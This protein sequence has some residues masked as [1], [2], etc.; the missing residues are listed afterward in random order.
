MSSN[1][2][3]SARLIESLRAVGQ[4]EQAA[5][6][7]RR[8]ARGLD[9]R[10]AVTVAAQL[11]NADAVAT[12]IA[13]TLGDPAAGATHAEWLGEFLAAQPETVVD[14]ALERARARGLPS[15]AE[16][17][18]AAVERVAVIALQ[19]TPCARLRAK[20]LVD[21]FLGK[22]FPDRRRALAEDLLARC[23]AQL[24]A[25]AIE[26]ITLEALVMLPGDQLSRLRAAAG[27]RQPALDRHLEG[28]ALQVLDALA[29]EAS[30]NVSRA[31]DSLGN[32]LYG[33]SSHFVLEFLQNADD[34]GARAWAIRFEPDRVVIQHD[35][36]AF[37]TRDVVGVTGI[38]QSTKRAGQI[39]TFGIGFKSVYQVTR[40]PRI[41]SGLF[42]FEIRDYV[43]PHPF[44]RRPDAPPG[45]TVFEL[46]LDEDRREL[47]G[48][49]LKQ[50]LSLDP[51]VLV[52]L[53][54]VREISFESRLGA[55][56]QRLVLKVSHDEDAGVHTVRRE[57]DGHAW[58][59]AIA[60]ADDPRAMVA[61]ELDKAGLPRR[62]E[63]DAPTVF[64]FLPTQEWSG[65]GFRL[66]GALELKMD[67]EHV[68]W[69]SARNERLLERVPGL[70]AEAV[71]KLVRRGGAQA[72]AAALAVL[73]A[74]ADNLQANF[75]RRLLPALPGALR[76]VP[77]I[78][79][80]DGQVRAPRAVIAYAR[81]LTPLL[82]HDPIDAYALG[83]P[84]PGSRLYPV[85]AALDERARQLASELGARALQ[86]SD[87]PELLERCLGR[88]PSG[89]RPT[90][91]WIPG[92][93]RRLD[94]G[95]LTA[96]HELL[97]VELLR[98]ERAPAAAP[99]ARRLIDVL[100]ALPLIPDD[101]LGL[102][103]SADPALRPVYA[104]Q[105]LRDIYEGSAAARV[106]VHRA[107]DPNIERKGAASRR[108][109]GAS[110]TLL[111]RLGVRTLTLADLLRELETRFSGRAQL[112]REQLARAPLPGDDRRLGKIFALMGTCE[113]TLLR[114]FSRLP[115]LPAAD[116]RHYPAAR[117]LEDVRGVIAAP[118][119][120]QAE[121]LTALYRGVRPLLQTTE[122][123]AA[124]AGVLERVRAPTLSVTTLIHDL[125]RAS[126]A[127]TGNP[128]TGL[129]DP[130]RLAEARSLL[131]VAAARLTPDDRGRALAL[132]IYPDEDGRLAPLGHV[133]EAISDQRVYACADRL[134]PYFKRTPGGPRLLEPAAQ[135]RVAPLLDAAGGLR[136]DLAALIEHILLRA[137]RAAERTA[138]QRRRALATVAQIFARCQATERAQIREVFRRE[139]I[140]LEDETGALRPAP[141]LL[142]PPPE[143]EAHVRAA[144]GEPPRPSP[145]Y[146][147]EIRDFLIEMG[148]RTLPTPQQ[149]AARVAAP[150]RERAAVIGLAALC[151]ALHR[152]HGDAVL[153]DPAPDTAPAP[154]DAEAEA[155]A[156]LGLGLTRAA[157]LLDARG[158]LRPPLELFR[159]TPDVIELLGARGELFLDPELE[160]ALAGLLP[161]LPLRGPGDVTLENVLAHIEHCRRQR[162]AVPHRVYRWLERA[163]AAGQLDPARLSG[164]SWVYTDNNRFFTHDRVFAVAAP[165]LFGHHRGYWWTGG[166]LCPTLWRR[167]IAQEVTT[168]HVLSF[169]REL[170]ER[171]LQSGDEALLASDPELP[172][173]LE[174]CYARAGAAE[175]TLP[176]GLPVILCFERGPSAS[177]T[178]RLL[179]ADAEKLWRSDTPALEA[180]YRAV[181]RFFVALRSSRHFLEVERFLERAGVGFLSDAQRVIVARERGVDRSAEHRGALED[182][183]RQLATLCDVL[184]RVEE[185]YRKREG[186]S[187]ASRWVYRQRLYQL[188]RTGALR[189]IEPLVVEYTLEGVGTHRDPHARAAHDPQNNALY[190]TGGLVERVAAHGLALAKCLVPL[191]VTG[192]TESLIPTIQLLLQLGD[193]EPALQRYLDEI[194][195]PQARPVYG[196]RERLL[197]RVGEL[198]RPEVG[199]RLAR[200][201]PALARAELSRW[202][203]GGWLEALALDDEGGAHG[204]DLSEETANAAARALLEHAGLNAERQPAL[205]DALARCLQA[206]SL[207][208]EL[209]ALVPQARAQPHAPAVEV[210]AASVPFRISYDPPVL[211]WPYSYVVYEPAEHFDRA[212][213]LWVSKQPPDLAQYLRGRP[214]GARVSFEGVFTPGTHPLPLPM[215][216]AL[217]GPPTAE[218]DARV[219]LGP[220]VHGLHTIEVDAGS[221][222]LATI[223]Y[224]ARLIDQPTPGPAPS[225]QLIEPTVSLSSLPAPLRARMASV[226][227][228]RSVWSQVGA[229]LEFVSKRY[230]YD[231]EAHEHT[232]A[233][234]AG[235]PGPGRGGGN[236]IL[237]SVHE[238]ADEQH[239]GRGA[240]FELNSLVVELL[241]HLGIPCML[242]SAWVLDGALIERPDHAFAIAFLPVVGGVVPVPVDAAAAAGDPRFAA[243]SAAANKAPQVFRDWDTRVRSGETI[244]V[245]PIELEQKLLATQQHAL[246]RIIELYCEHYRV[247]TPAPLRRIASRP[248]LDPRARM[249]ATRA[250]AAALSRDERFTALLK[251]A[252]RGS[253]RVWGEVLARG[254]S[255]AARQRG[256]E[257]R[258]SFLRA[259]VSEGLIQITPEL[260]EGS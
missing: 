244:T 28:L 94:T 139:A 20:C 183:Q 26:S 255:V 260:I 123:T 34:A 70:L 105:G 212:R 254:I 131:A 68:K 190:V 41:S 90:E 43:S 57:P 32:R 209:D 124:A 19:R 121:R 135:E 15:A 66:Q 137:Y 40:C 54:S 158:D 132:P 33:E 165:E 101:R 151:A 21:R 161:R 194:G 252:S 12:I 249:A 13:D 117:G 4:A 169:L 199:L 220:R 226:K 215:F 195:C 155:P 27:A 79:C 207:A 115:L 93:L 140:E 242:A 11:R 30:L 97:L 51:F 52:S 55:R 126:E 235:G 227:N 205:L 259:L 202:R 74:R 96:L 178:P 243:A 145:A 162:A 216:S 164:R 88:L 180:R 103:R 228:L 127:P 53:Q 17:I 107:L 192:A 7:A 65:L 81:E 35:G 204:N 95:A 50:A 129:L 113:P 250:A 214:E 122:A 232:I 91:P 256:D 78:P 156:A 186:A 29:Q 130:A 59:H 102:H 110:K 76:D 189:V 49:L 246:R 109:G 188:A 172:H 198:L 144:L 128:I 8:R 253:E 167:L 219:L 236:F 119:G 48:A 238:A 245:D 87:L 174:A 237:N 234:L 62:A 173:L 187:P 208:D 142:L 39:G 240:C 257:R 42:R 143:L 149:V 153:D 73:P 147:E 44:R 18:A 85:D 64:C 211:P 125:E 181:G 3:E 72:A 75:R 31:A 84:E 71:G 141:E 251:L 138:E 47:V 159:R 111:A 258:A 184:P 150:P 229:I 23:R 25:D 10:A 176:A 89:A 134:R 2:D 56:P 108:P 114:R 191:I 106:F 222:E 152:E 80:A 201:F 171:A 239:L 197:E 193:D 63:D 86:T 185:M 223:R 225:P 231:L 213:Q 206:R 24:D 170:G 45:W 179:A 38:G 99:S 98:R 221:R 146:P 224:S 82:G 166:S 168:E 9:A 36:A 58:R 118:A 116:G 154:E 77:C 46:P 60:S 83:A 120:P 5:E 175:Q 100:A 1:G 210:E 203:A 182:L 136:L 22:H 247:R 6:L 233:G 160:T 177:P 16:A 61:I 37:D 200:R 163:H 248:E 157:W 217:A 92:A 148:V 196:P 14:A 112:T 133:R 104:G 69:S 218:G 230:R 67:R 241:R